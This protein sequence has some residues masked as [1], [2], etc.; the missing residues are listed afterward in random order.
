MG[1]LLLDLDVL[2]LRKLPKLLR[3]RTNTCASV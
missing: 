1:A 3:T 2:G